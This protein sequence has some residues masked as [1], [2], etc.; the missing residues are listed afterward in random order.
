MVALTLRGFYAILDLRERPPTD[1]AEVLARAEELLRAQPCALQLRAKTLP[2]NTVREVAA[3]ILPACHAAHVPFCVNDRLDIALA[4]GA[5]MV[6]V[7]QN[8]LPL[9]EVLKLIRSVEGPAMAV[10]VST[11]NQEQARAAVK[12]GADYIGFGPIFST[13][14]KDNPDP[15][16]GL[17]T[18][19]RITS[20]IAVPVVAIGGVSRSNVADVAAA[21]A[22][23]AA[24]ISD[25]L[26]AAD[27][28]QAG[29][30]IAAPFLALPAR[31]TRARRRRQPKRPVM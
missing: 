23:A 11:H 24:V 26:T 7:G 13:S 15:I 20:E 9:I 19:E 5:D 30:D 22:D 3:R 17:E 6:H 8:D 31:Q 18:L 27:P 4:V 2:A 10:G 25:V 28:T 16:V 12:G 14:S 1:G 21:G 29:L